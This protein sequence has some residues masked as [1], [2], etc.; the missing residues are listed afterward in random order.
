VQIVT[1]RLR[2]FQRSNFGVIEV[3]IEV[4][5]LAQNRRRLRPQQN[6]ANSRI[7][8]GERRSVAGEL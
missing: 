2:L 1:R 3:V 5:T 8:R 6:A 7:R 4:C